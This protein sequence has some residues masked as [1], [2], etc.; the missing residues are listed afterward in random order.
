MKTP[1]LDKMLKI[2]TDSQ[3]IGE[4]LEWL[5][6]EEITLA[7]W[8]GSDCEECGEETLMLIS[9]NREHL[10]AKYFCIDLEKAEIER[11]ALLNDVRAKN[12]KKTV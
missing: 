2:R 4:F 3:R 11:Q 7:E 8:S 12:T 6:G 9:M 5:E 10:L 1:E